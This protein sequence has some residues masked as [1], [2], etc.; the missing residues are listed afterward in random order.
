VE[1]IAIWTVAL[2]ALYASRHACTL[3]G[4]VLCARTRT[5]R[6]PKGG[7]RRI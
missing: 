2:P 5:R 6:C 4:R 1:F 7:A 3:S